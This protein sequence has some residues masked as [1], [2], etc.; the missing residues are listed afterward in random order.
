MPCLPPGENLFCVAFVAN[1]SVLFLGVYADALDSTC[2][3]YYNYE[4]AAYANFATITDFYG[5]NV[6]YLLMFHS[7]TGCDTASYYNF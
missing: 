3:W 1:D 2:N 6:N 4:A 5:N 7:I